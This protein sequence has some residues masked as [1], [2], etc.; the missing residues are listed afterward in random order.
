MG[1]R[2]GY[3]SSLSRL[4]AAL[5]RTRPQPSPDRLN[6]IT[7]TRAQAETPLNRFRREHGDVEPTLSMMPWRG[8]GVWPGRVPLPS[9]K[10]AAAARIEQEFPSVLRPALPASLGPL[11]TAGPMTG[12]MQTLSPYDLARMRGLLN[13]LGK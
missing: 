9:V 13:L 11:A 7:G 1:L 5:A 12:A 2:P 3:Q 8:R 6:Q 4:L 10:A